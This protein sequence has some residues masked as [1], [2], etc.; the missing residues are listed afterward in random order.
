MTHWVTTKHEKTAV[1]GAGFKPA[2]T[3]PQQR[4][5]VV[6]NLFSSKFYNKNFSAGRMNYKKK[7]DD[8]LLQKCCFILIPMLR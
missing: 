1:V 2:P 6:K 3:E 8:F 5:K 7:G 4:P